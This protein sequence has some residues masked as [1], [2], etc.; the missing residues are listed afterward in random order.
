M[1]DSS[2]PDWWNRARDLERAGQLNAAEQLLKDAIPHQ[3]CALEIAEL[4]R[5]RM[6]RLRSEGDVAGA[7]EAWLESY[8]WASFYASQATSGGEGA[9]LSR[10]RDK[11]H[12]QLGPR[13]S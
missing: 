6:I 3:A 1:N 8:N 12:A 4:Y 10:E 2:K 5:D 11:F 9:A 7:G 13:P